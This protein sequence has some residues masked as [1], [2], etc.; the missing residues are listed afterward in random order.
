MMND[1]D[2]DFLNLEL[3]KASGIKPKLKIN[4]GPT[5]SKLVEKNLGF[6]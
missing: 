6:N 5:K 2:L 1:Q 4:V 3:Q